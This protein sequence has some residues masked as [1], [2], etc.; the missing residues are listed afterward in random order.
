MLSLKMCELCELSTT[1]FRGLGY[2]LEGLLSNL[3][4]SEG[5][6]QDLPIKR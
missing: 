5:F 2:P 6:H 3:P 1:P 4:F